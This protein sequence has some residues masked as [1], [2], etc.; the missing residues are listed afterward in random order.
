M[1]HYR[2]YQNTAK[3]SC[4]EYDSARFT[5]KANLSIT[6][7]WGNVS[8]STIPKHCKIAADRQPKMYISHNPRSR[9]R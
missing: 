6:F 8:L 1:Y 9:I 2:P 7:L 4:D 5:Q 3:Y